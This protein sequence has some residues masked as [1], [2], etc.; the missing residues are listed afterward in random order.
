M[1]KT[2]HVE[3]SQRRTVLPVLLAV[4]RVVAV[5]RK[6]PLRVLL[7]FVSVGWDEGMGTNSELL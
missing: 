2:L 7:F 5:V 6:P 3:K 1:N 4:V